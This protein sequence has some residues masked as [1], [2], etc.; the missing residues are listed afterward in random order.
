P[1]EHMKRTSLV[2]VAR[3]LIPQESRS[4][5]SYFFDYG[6]VAL[7]SFANFQRL[8]AH[9][10]RRIRGLISKPK[11]PEGKALRI[12]AVLLELSGAVSFDLYALSGKVET[13]FEVAKES[14]RCYGFFRL[15][16]FLRHK[17][18]G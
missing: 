6:A 16:F 13:T 18:V 11:I 2:V 4:E 7:I 14:F 17:F 8:E 5:F 3:D 1:S 15:W 9:Q 10:V 12:V